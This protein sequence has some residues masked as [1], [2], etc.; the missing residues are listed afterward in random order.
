MATYLNPWNEALRLRSALA[1]FGVEEGE[2]AFPAGSGF[3]DLATCCLVSAA[4][5][6]AAAISPTQ[7]QAIQAALRPFRIPLEGRS[8]RLDA[9][10]VAMFEG[11]S[12]DYL[13]AW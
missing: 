7:A 10:A 5:G 9:G 4:I 3:E 2:I 6:E 13:V 11:D 8:I 12:G 1:S